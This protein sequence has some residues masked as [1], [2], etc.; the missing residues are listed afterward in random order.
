[1]GR[2]LQGSEGIEAGV[3]K[4]EDRRCVCV[5]GGEEVLKLGIGWEGCC[6]TAH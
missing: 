2:I 4:V 3:R 1:M 5:A 6:G